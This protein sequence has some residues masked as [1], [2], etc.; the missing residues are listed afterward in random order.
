[1]EFY[2]TRDANPKYVNDF[3]NCKPEFHDYILGTSL[4]SMNQTGSLTT[5]RFCSGWRE[6]DCRDSCERGESASYR[7]NSPKNSFSLL[8]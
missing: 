4:E 2:G 7:S 3:E 8:V 1:M 6:R 5:M